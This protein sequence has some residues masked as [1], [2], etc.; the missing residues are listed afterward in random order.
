MPVRPPLSVSGWSYDVTA[1]LQNHWIIF[2]IILVV[3]CDNHERNSRCSVHDGL[4]GFRCLAS[5]FY[6]G[7]SLN[8]EQFDNPDGPPGVFW[9]G[10]E[11]PHV[12]QIQIRDGWRLSQ[13][14]E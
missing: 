12:E 9:I 2:K 3:C 8:T 6:S 7:M 11:C 10:D 5:A 14:E 13:S 1:V 4:G